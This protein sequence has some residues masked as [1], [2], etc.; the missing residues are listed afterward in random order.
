MAKSYRQRSC[1]V[2]RTLD[3]IGERWS[4]LILR[5]LFLHGPRRFQDFQDSLAGVAPNTLSARLKTLEAQG[6][7]ERRLY[8]DHPP[9][10]EYH[11]TEKGRDLGP[12]LRAL[13][14]WGDD[15]G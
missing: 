2:A 5:D 4:I 14:K 10:L 8:S 15:Y 6:V 9:R 7:I 11:L 3:V 13:K 1:P 12:V